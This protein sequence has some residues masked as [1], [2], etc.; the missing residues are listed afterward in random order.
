MRAL[1]KWV[2]P[3]LAGGAL[4]V[5]VA[6]CS[7]GGGG[8]GGPS[9]LDLVSKC[10]QICAQ[11]GTCGAS[12]ALV[13]QCQS[14]CGDL[15]LAPLGCLD[16]FAAYLACLGGANSVQC[17][18]GPGQ[19]YVFV[20]PPQCEADRQN[21]VGCNAGPSPVAACVQLP[22]NSACGIGAPA[23]MHDTFCVGEP[24]VCTSLQP[25]PLGIGTFCCPSTS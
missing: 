19:A 24:S 2:A 10:D 11:V 16:P 8:G 3:V 4:V 12:P 15:A 17:S 22:G 21:L 9:G 6:S 5:G 14:A 13:S 25:N 18:T 23:Q 7:S 20:T 1:W